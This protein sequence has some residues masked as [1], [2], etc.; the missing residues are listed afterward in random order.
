MVTKDKG[1]I[2][3]VTGTGTSG[4][5]FIDPADPKIHAPR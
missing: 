4:T 1:A 2:V 5:T 3:Q